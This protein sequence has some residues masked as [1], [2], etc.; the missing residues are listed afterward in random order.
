MMQAGAGRRGARRRPSAPSRSMR[1]TSAPRSASN[2]AAK[3]PYAP[4]RST[5]RT[6]SRRSAAGTTASFHARGSGPQ[7]CGGEPFG[8]SRY[9]DGD[10]SGGSHG[11][12]AV[13]VPAPRQ[14]QDAVRSST[15]TGVTSTGRCW[16]T[17]PDL[18]RHVTRY[19]LNHRLPDDLGGASL[20]DEVRDDGWDGVAVLWLE[21]M[22]ELRALS[23]EPGMAPIRERAP[24]P[25]PGRAPHR[26]HRGSRRHRLDAAAR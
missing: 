19:E 3:L 18:R 22:E 20:A 14:G 12:Q 10:R 2:F 26:R 13:R 24:Q 1:T 9:G 15:P 11:H 16:R 25:A 17:I 7:R 4:V 6:S 5:T 8:P 21:S 23:A